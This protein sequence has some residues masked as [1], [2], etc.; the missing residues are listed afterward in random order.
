MREADRF[1]TLSVPESLFQRTLTSF[2]FGLVW[3]QLMVEDFH[4]LK[5]NFYQFK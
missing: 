4:N 5:E 1:A 3:L 2:R